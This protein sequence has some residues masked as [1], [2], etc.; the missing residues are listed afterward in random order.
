MTPLN[1][2]KDELYEMIKAGGHKL[3]SALTALINEEQAKNSIKAY[4]FKRGMRP[5]DFED[6]FFSALEDLVVAVQSG[7]FKPGGDIAGYLFGMCRNK[8]Y[9]WTRKQNRAS[10]GEHITVHY[11]SSEDP[12]AEDALIVEEEKKAAWARFEQLGE[13]CKQ[14][15]RLAFFERKKN[16]EIARIV[17][18]KNERVVRVKKHKCLKQLWA[19]SE[20]E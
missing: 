8:W 11:S 18:Y 12:S 13:M 7:R 14:I 3:N 17:N 2:S 20:N 10:D 19:L 15:L 5:D 9:N 6:I 4:F 16:E 1:Y